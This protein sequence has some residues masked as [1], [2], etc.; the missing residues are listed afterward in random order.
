MR[1]QQIVYRA[2]DPASDLDPLSG[3]G[4]RASGNRFN[5]QGVPALY[6][7]LD[8]MTALRE[9]AQD[10]SRLQPTLLVTIEI[11][12]APVFDA[13][14]HDLLATRGVTMDQLS[15]EDWRD[16]ID[17]AGRPET[18][19]FARRL[20]DDGF[21]GLLAPSFC[22]GSARSDR[23]LVLWNWGANPPTRA[24]LVDDDERLVGREDRA[25]R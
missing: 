15:A 25:R 17:P 12:I 18:Q 20:I 1:F 2:L 4:A 3:E 16:T 5:P 11:D 22:A 19:A 24:H 10:T 23:N 7:S 9:F 21:A 13:T 14:D 8:V 6:T